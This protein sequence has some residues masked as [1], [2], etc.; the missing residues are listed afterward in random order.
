MDTRLIAEM[1]VESFW[2][3]YGGKEQ[4]GEKQLFFRYSFT[5]E[6]SP[7]EQREIV[8]NLVNLLSEDLT[9]FQIYTHS[10]SINIVAAIDC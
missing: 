2:A 10:N 1:I 5:H 4:L 6:H 7:D 9:T 8:S 3:E